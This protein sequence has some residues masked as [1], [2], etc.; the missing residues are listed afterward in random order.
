MIDNHGFIN[1]KEYKTIDLFKLICAFLVVAIH[2]EPGSFNVWVDRAI[3]ILTRIAVPYFFVASGFLYCLNKSELTSDDLFKYVKR[4]GLLYL[5][6]IVLYLPF[7]YKDVFCNANVLD[8]IKILLNG[9]IAIHLW[10]LP[11]N[12]LAVI[13][14]H[15]LSKVLSRKNVLLISFV[16]LVFGII[17]S[18]YNIIGNYNSVLFN[19][20]NTIN[21]TIG[22]R[23][24]LFYGFFY[25]SLGAYIQENSNKENVLKRDIVLFVISLI[26]LAAESYVAVIYLEPKFTILWFSQIPVA[27]FMFKMSLA[28]DLPIDKSVAKNIRNTSTIIYNVHL[29]F[30]CLIETILS[31]NEGPL[32]FVLVSVLSLIISYLIIKLSNKFKI[33]KY[34]Y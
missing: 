8:I 19:F 11:A 15:L 29:V 16:F 6:N 30:I 14:F 17:C 24:G 12:I 27:Y 31:I 25:V 3:G 23:N 20:I 26:A 18:T 7:T 32:M 21:N 34:L 10:Y 22:T 2:T 1:N 28:I 13:L 5:I 4:V 9:D 33:L